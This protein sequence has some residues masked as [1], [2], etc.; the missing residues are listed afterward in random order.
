MNYNIGCVRKQKRFI[1]KKVNVENTTFQK[2]EEDLSTTKLLIL[3]LDR[4]AVQKMSDVATGEEN[5]SVF[6]FYY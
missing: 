3:L 6:I 2:K 4:L 1:S 5:R